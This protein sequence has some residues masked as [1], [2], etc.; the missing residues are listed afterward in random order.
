MHR[1]ET[2]FHPVQDPEGFGELFVGHVQLEGGKVSIGV[3]PGTHRSSVCEP[4]PVLQVLGQVILVPGG[5][6]F[7]RVAVF[8]RDVVLCAVPGCDGAFLSREAE[9]ALWQQV[10]TV[11]PARRRAFE[12]S[13]KGRKR[14]PAPWPPNPG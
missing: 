13:S 3:E 11:A 6:D 5:P 8:V 2:D 14:R 12:P 10:F 7:R 4:A 1:D 9:D